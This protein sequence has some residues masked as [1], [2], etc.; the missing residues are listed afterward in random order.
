MESENA[1]L[2]VGF[3]SC[4][5]KLRSDWKQRWYN[6]T[7]LTITMPRTSEE[8]ICTYKHHLEI[9]LYPGWVNHLWYTYWIILSYIKKK[10]LWR[11]N[12]GDWSPQCIV[13]WN[14]RLTRLETSFTFHEWW[15]LIRNSPS[16]TWVPLCTMTNLEDSWSWLEVHTKELSLCGTCRLYLGWNQQ[17]WTH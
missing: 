4:M 16:L 1:F 17:L 3:F 9:F 11:T 8:F 7:W 6:M 10:K 12:V 13:L 2:F 5:A 15:F 14:V